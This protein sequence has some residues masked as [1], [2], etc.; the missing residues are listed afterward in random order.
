[1]IDQRLK[2]L[3]LAR[4]L[5]L[6][7][8]AAAIG[9]AV[10]KQALSKYERGKARPSPVVL[11]KLADALGVKA[12]YL[13][14]EPAIEVDFIAYRKRSALPKKEQTRVEGLV[15]EVLETRVRLQE[16]LGYTEEVDLP[17]QEVQIASAEEAEQA[18][19]ELR[20]RWQLGLDPIAE[21]VDVLEHRFVH[22]LQIEA[23]EKFDGISAVAYDRDRRR[24]AVAVVTRQ[25]VPGERQ[26]L[27]LAH[28]LGHLVLKVSP[29]VDQ[30]RAA[31]RF[32]AAFLAPAPVIRREVGNRRTFIQPQEL[33]L[34]KRRFGLSL[35]ALLF[36]LRDLAI[37][38]ESYYRQW[39]IDINRLGWRHHEPLDL[40]PEQ[41][42]WL[43]R[44]ALRAL[45]EGLISQE[46]AESIMGERIQ[47][48]VPLPAVERRA[49]MKLPLE[50]RRRLLAEQAEKLVAHYDQ[51]SEW[52]DLE[53]G[54]FVDY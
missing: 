44:S 35:Q 25:G 50:E 16:L 46:E 9:G 49:F 14:S 24:R 37:I 10:T 48:D 23:G 13:W 6:D 41:P 43:H 28:E 8:L 26:R 15:A 18:A 4:G 21:L 3:R 52:R 29:D 17:V 53:A 7:A 45:A 30:E 32:G 33:L 54:D 39:C 1:M 42:Q 36:R 2:Q 47:A 5:S 20:K 34:L 51:D 27:N 38:A 11:N 31:F 12:A 40:S 19:Q 22:V